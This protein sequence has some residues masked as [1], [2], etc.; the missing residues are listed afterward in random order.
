MDQVTW[1]LFSHFERHIERHF[2]NSVFSSTT[3]TL[4]YCFIVVVGCAR[5]L[6]CSSSTKR[7]NCSALHT[8]IPTPTTRAGQIGPT[9]PKLVGP[10]RQK[11]KR[12]GI[13]RVVRLSGVLFQFEMGSYGQAW[14]IRM[15]LLKARNRPQIQNIC[16]IIILYTLQTISLMSHLS[17]KRTAHKDTCHF[18]ITFISLFKTLLVTFA[19]FFV[20]TFF[21]PISIKLRG[22][23]R[24][25]LYFVLP[26]ILFIR[27][28]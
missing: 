17:V 10:R 25:F 5:K 7:D 11:C 3:F 19:E 26:P 8:L 9:R 18:F 23:V 6:N 28:I 1:F 12:A 27:N 20:I 21:I 14:G 22:W 2:K 24:L 4:F 13:S 16:F 15:N